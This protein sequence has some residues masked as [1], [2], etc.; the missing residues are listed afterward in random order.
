MRL[1]ELYDRIGSQLKIN[2]DAK[3]WEVR[4]KTAN[5]SIGPMSSDGVY[6]A[7][8]GIDWDHG[9]YFIFPEDPLEKRAQNP[10]GRE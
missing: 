10:A 9:K 5:P 3:E 8:P 6:S 1:Q 2:R 7:G 4:I